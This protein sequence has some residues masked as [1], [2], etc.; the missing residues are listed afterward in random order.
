MTG[1]LRYGVIGLGE[2]GK[3]HVAGITR[4]AEAE[5]VAV[6]D[7]NPQ[8]LS[9]TAATTGARTYTAGE[10]LLADPGVEAVTLCVPHKFHARL[11]EQAL[12]AGKHVLIEKPMAVT[13]EECDRLIA[14]A[15]RK[16]LVLAAS[17]NQTFYPP[18]AWLR[19]QIAG[20]G[21]ARPSMLRLRLAI[22]GKYGGWRSN[23]DLTGGGLLFDAG[24]HRFY[25]ARYLMGEVIA[26][27]ARMDT[28]DP[29]STGE[30]HAIVVLEFRDGGLGVIEAGYFGPAGA[31]DDQVEAVTPDGLI[32][33]PGVEAHFERFS[34][35]PAVLVWKDAAWR[36]VDVEAVDW[37][38]TVHRSAADFVNAIRSGTRPRADGT[39]G[40][41]IVKLVEAAYRSA[42]EGRRVEV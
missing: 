12:G 4:L 7:L 10:D 17:H 36:S 41:R 16:G 35:E 39:E 11:C 42:K 40:Q 3:H 30:N 38:Q 27:T 6:A 28:T 20:G 5:L 33:I 31:F 15:A 32:R 8:L 23:P 18:H 2:V 19:E 26:V 29:R 1:R 25:V 24:F 22:G 14:L 34:S 9:Q 13:S 37:A 21:V